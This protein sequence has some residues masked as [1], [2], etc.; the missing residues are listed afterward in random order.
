MGER[1]KKILELFGIT[2]N[3]ETDSEEWHAEQKRKLEAGEEIEPPWIAFPKS[4][5]IVLWVDWRHGNGWLDNIWKPFWNGLNITEKKEY[6]KKWQPPNDEWYETVTIYWDKGV[7]EKAEWYKKQM[8]NAKA[9]I[10]V[11]PPW[12]VFPLSSPDYGWDNGYGEQWKLDIW[13]PFWKK[14]N[15]REQE[16]Y[17]E[18]WQPSEE[19]KI[20]LTVNWKNKL[21]KSDRWHKSQ[22]ESEFWQGEVDLPWRAFP[23]NSSVYEWDEKEK[24]YWLEENWLPFWNKL[25]AEKQ[26]EYLKFKLM[27]DDEWIETLAEYQVKNFD[28]LKIRKEVKKG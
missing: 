25:S 17:L 4:N 6:L 7:T 8:E 19:W 22:R 16:R 2:K 15:E 5:P 3:Q 26:D 24:D 12:V 28:K 14:L 20:T 21:K 18:K 27:P 1:I 23:N 10:E 9:G 13:L 11:E